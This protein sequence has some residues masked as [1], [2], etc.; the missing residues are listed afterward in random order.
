MQRTPII[1]HQNFTQ[2]NKVGPSSNHPPSL[3][4]MRLG[5]SKKIKETRAA[6]SYI[7]NLPKFTQ[8]I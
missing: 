6:N 5:M 4:R 1:T 7:N 8:K 3:H 2:K